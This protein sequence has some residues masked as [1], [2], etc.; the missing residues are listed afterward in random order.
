M[1]KR[2]DGL[3]KKYL[4]EGDPDLNRIMESNDE[5]L[6]RTNEADVQKLKDFDRTLDE[7]TK[8]LDELEQKFGEEVTIKAEKLLDSATSQKVRAHKAADAAPN[9]AGGKHEADLAKIATDAEHIQGE[10]SKGTP[11]PKTLADFEAT[12]DKNNRSLQ[13]IE[14]DLGLAPTVQL[15]RPSL[16][17]GTKRA[18]EAAA[19]KTP[20]GKF[21]DPH[22]PNQTIDGPW[23]YGHKYGREN[24]RLIREAT[25][26]GM[27]QEQFNDWVNSHPE[28]FQIEG[29]TDNISHAFE[30][31]GVD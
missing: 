10:L 14:R 20:D 23:D 5:V 21:I 22:R 30:K 24:R 3:A 12:L 16:R 29:H 9:K 4:K 27:T 26:S 1:N 6:T 2:A 19:P 28:W 18:I 15:E 31:P 13:D 8:K 25:E 17:E 7:N 11:D